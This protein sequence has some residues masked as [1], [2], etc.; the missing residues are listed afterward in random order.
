MSQTD[1]NKPMHVYHEMVSEMHQIEGWTRS[2]GLIPIGR[3][4]LCRGTGAVIPVRNSGPK[5]LAQ[6]F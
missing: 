6:K 5:I 3:Y 1:V 4:S 2:A